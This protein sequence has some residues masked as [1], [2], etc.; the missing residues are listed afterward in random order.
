M[1][2]EYILNHF[3]IEPFRYLPISAFKHTDIKQASFAIKYSNSNSI[4]RF[5]VYKQNYSNLPQK[6]VKKGVLA[7]SW[8][9]NNSVERKINLISNLK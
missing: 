3:G 4:L 1:T 5:F 6:A 2:I 7:A 9:E 8:S